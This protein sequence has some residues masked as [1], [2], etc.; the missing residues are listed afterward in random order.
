[1]TEPIHISALCQGCNGRLVQDADFKDEW[2]CPVCKDSIYLD[3]PRNKIEVLEKTF[4]KSFVKPGRP[5]SELRAE[6]KRK[7]NKLDS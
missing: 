2:R 5:W 1:M 4:V 6:Y 7:N 3:W